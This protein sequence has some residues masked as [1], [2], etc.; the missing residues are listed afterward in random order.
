MVLESYLVGDND[1]SCLK[2]KMLES[3][4]TV[5]FTGVVDRN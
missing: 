1:L 4:G 2:M 3:K 5:W